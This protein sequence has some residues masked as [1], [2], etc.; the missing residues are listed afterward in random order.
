MLR[1]R[2]A[3]RVAWAVVSVLL[4][5]SARQ[6]AACVVI[7]ALYTIHFTLLKVGRLTGQR[8]M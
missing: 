8:A 2:L 1:L 7:R 3:W 6:R 5:S 4:A